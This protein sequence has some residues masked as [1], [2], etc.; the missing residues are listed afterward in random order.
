MTDL[1]RLGKY[2]V[3]FL[4]SPHFGAQG[5]N[6]YFE[7]LEEEKKIQEYVN[8]QEE[9]TLTVKEMAEELKPIAQQMPNQAQ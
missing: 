3:D 2:L 6:I 5:V 4:N 8:G 7:W 1:Y 9:R